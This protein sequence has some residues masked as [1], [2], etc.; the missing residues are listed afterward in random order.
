[1]GLGLATL[2]HDARQVELL[3]LLYRRLVRSRIRARVRVRVRI[4]VRVRVRV[5]R[6]LR[7]RPRLRVRV[8]SGASTVSGSSR[9]FAII[10]R[11]FGR[12]SLSRVAA[13]PASSSDLFE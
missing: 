10:R 11:T 1:L 9:A 2:L 8:C 5:G 4:R 3:E 6:R 13:T 7:G 12:V